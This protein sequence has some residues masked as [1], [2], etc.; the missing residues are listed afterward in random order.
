MALKLHFHS[1]SR[2]LS[3]FSG[4]G[5]LNH[6]LAYKI[7]SLALLLSVTTSVSVLADEYFTD[8]NE[9]KQ[10]E[11]RIAANQKAGK[12]TIVF[13]TGRDVTTGRTWCGP[14]RQFEAQLGSLKPN[15]AVDVIRVSL[16]SDGSDPKW[17]KYGITGVP[18]LKTAVIADGKMSWTVVDSSKALSIVQSGTLNAPIA[19][20]NQTKQEKKGEII[21]TTYNETVIPPKVK[22]KMKIGGT[23]ELSVETSGTTFPSVITKSGEKK[24]DYLML[25]DGK[26]HLK[27]EGSY[28][29]LAINNEGKLTTDLVQRLPITDEKA[30]NDLLMWLD[31][32]EVT[33]PDE[34][35]TKFQRQFIKTELAPLP[36]EISM[37]HGKR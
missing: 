17:T 11:E 29:P 9:N 33:S 5:I 24:L 20:S 8:V 37:T 31:T 3:F 34:R 25:S 14:C 13:F 10:I 18:T 36:R 22:G 15:A 32:V 19:K 30:V 28:K 4:E 12:Q 16:S 2:L 26:V 35:Y 27:F 6:T 21:Q 7:L 23:G 1:Q